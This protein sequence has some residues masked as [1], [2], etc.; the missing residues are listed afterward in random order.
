MDTQPSPGGDAS[1]ILAASLWRDIKA[2]LAWWKRKGWEASNRRSSRGSIMIKNNAGRD[3]GAGEFLQLE[4][5]TQPAD[6]TLGITTNYTPIMSAT[7][8]TWHSAIDNI[9]IA[10]SPV[11]DGEYFPYQPHPF[12][13]VKCSGSK[14]SALR[15]VMP[16]PSDPKYAIRCSSGLYRILGYDAVNE[17][18]IVDLGKSQ[19]RWRYK[20]T[21]DAQVSGSTEAKL[22]TTDGV[23]FSSTTIILSDPLGVGDEDSIDFEGYCKNAGNEFLIASGPC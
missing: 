10:D 9:V 15:Y 3:V 5:M 22:Y 14:G 1:G 18:A 19:S 4:S 2:M 7:T 12:G 17:F 13:I 16:D 23:E 20:L 8:P 21:E 11:I 6:S